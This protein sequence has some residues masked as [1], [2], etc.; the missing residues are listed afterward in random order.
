[1]IASAI[2]GLFSF[3]LIL[4]AL[5]VITARN[6]VHAVLFLIFAFFNAAGL[7]V[8]MGAEFLGMILAIVYVGAVAVLFLFVV[9]MLDIDFADLRRGSLRYAPLG[10]ALG[11]IL[12]AEFYLMM[13][14]GAPV[15]LNL[16][17]ETGAPAGD[18]TSDIG[19]VLYTDY[20]LPFQMA[21]M[22]LLVAMVGAIVL[23]M[24]KRAGVKRQSIKA[25]SER[26]PADVVRLTQ[27]KSGEGVTLW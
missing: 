4:S 6:P 9:M 7:F 1:M 12:M 23:T 15:I 8:M 3:F 14:A 11:L 17:A 2:L 18:N 26:D 25:Q 27:P 13:A 19:G 22:V 16:A 21:G 24:R 20:I 5:M 10:A